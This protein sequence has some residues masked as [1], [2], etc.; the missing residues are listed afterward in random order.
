MEAAASNRKVRQ[1]TLSSVW[2]PVRDWNMHEQQVHL[3][4]GYP[5][6]VSPPNDAWPSKCLAIFL[7][8]LTFVQMFHV[9]IAYEEFGEGLRM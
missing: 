1:W 3:I 7:E 2:D 4:F 8:E 5:D 9:L 6:G